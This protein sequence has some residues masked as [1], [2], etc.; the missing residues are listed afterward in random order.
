MSLL[1]KQT[2]PCTIAVSNPDLSIYKSGNHLRDPKA[3][4]RL[5]VNVAPHPHEPLLGETSPFV[6]S[7]SPT[8]GQ[9]RLD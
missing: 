7:A 4:K 9:Q 2:D 8:R 3:K 5:R 6:I 1:V